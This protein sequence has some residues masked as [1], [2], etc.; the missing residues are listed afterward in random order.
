MFHPIHHRE[1]ADMPK[2]WAQICIQRVVQLSKEST[3]MRRVLDPMFVY[4][5]TRQQW[6]PSGLAFIVLSDMAYFMDTPGNFVFVSICSL[7]SHILFICYCANLEINL[8]WSSFV[9]LYWWAHYI[10]IIKLVWKYVELPHRPLKFRLH[11]DWPHPLWL[12]N[13]LNFVISNNFGLRY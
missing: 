3:T 11:F 5:D 4:F 12:L 13:L 7:S 2:V 10:H 1:E 8:L 6:V 9:L